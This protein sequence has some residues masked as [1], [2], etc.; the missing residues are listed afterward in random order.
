MNLEMEISGAKTERGTPGPPRRAPVH[1]H[2]L[3]TLMDY[4]QRTLDCIVMQGALC[5]P[6]RRTPV[7]F[8]LQYFTSQSLLH[9]PG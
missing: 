5:H 1:A 4:L 8:F 3:S 6:A 7:E 2:R 9:E